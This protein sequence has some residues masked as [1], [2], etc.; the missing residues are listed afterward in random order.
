MEEFKN[1]KVTVILNGSTTERTTGK[2]TE[3]VEGVFVRPTL[4]NGDNGIIIKIFKSSDQKIGTYR[5]IPFTSILYMESE[6]ITFQ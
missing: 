2:K 1:K 3:S 5:F 4:F 6:I